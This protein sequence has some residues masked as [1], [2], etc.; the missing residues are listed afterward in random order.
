MVSEHINIEQILPH[1]SYWYIDASYHFENLTNDTVTISVAFPEPKYDSVPRFDSFKTI[2]RGAQADYSVAHMA[3]DSL[4]YRIGRSYVFD[5][6]FLPHEHLDVKHT[7]CY[8]GTSWAWAVGAEYLTRTGRSWHGSIASAEFVLTTY[9]L[10]PSGQGLIYDDEYHLVDCYREVVK[11][12]DFRSAIADYYNQVEGFKDLQITR[13]VCTFKQQHWTPERDFF[14]MLPYRNE[15]LTICGNDRDLW[16]RSF[17]LHYPEH[18]STLLA[19]H[20]DTLY[21]RLECLPD[22]LL[23][24]YRNHLYAVYGRPFSNR[25]LHRQFYQQYVGSDLFDEEEAGHF[26]RYEYMPNSR[27]KDELISPLEREFILRLKS[28]EQRRQKQAAVYGG[29]S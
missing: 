4:G 9:D 5:V 18:L 20:V 3:V 11:D 17:F 12:P 16:E 25:E 28:V 26:I 14:V 1:R 24:F 7:Y 15:E 10:G 22:S 23:R 19:L 2:I 21:Q 13:T 27:Y 29:S 6:T 8:R